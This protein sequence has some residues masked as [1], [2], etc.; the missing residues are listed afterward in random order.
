MSR[1]L[2]DR[3]TALVTGANAGIGYATAVGLARLGFRVAM[4]CRDPARGK[5][6][7]RAARA[8]VAEAELDLVLGDLSRPV[9]AR[10]AAKETAQR[11]PDLKVLVN[12]A[13]ILPRT[14]QETADGIELQ[15]AVNHLA[16]AVLADELLP[17]LRHNRP[18]RVVNVASEAHRRGRL[19]LD[20]L[21]AARRYRPRPHYN[22]TK[23]MNV[24]FSMELARRIEGSGVT[25]NA[26]HPGV[27]PTG[28]LRNFL[29][30]PAFARPLLR[31]FL[32]SEEDGAK[33]SVHVAGSRAL[34]DRNGG[35]WK[36]EAELEASVA[37]QDRENG[38]ALWQ[39]TAGILAGLAS[40]ITI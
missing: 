19:D 9:L 29:G 14:R 28:L 5:A 13:A 25:S 30:F 2:P 26:L 24:L 3:G 37:A 15:F 34:D 17:I 22:N 32:K 7:L 6:A 21:Q 36:D 38:R 35:Y 39:R 27:I 1:L 33:T 23:L 10:H 40:P 8:E 16:Y 18:A 12:N 20:D 4:L 31:V 11:F